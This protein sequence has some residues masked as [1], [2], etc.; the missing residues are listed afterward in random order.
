MAVIDSEVQMELN[1]EPARPE[2]APHVPE[3]LRQRITVQVS[4]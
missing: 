2:D 3:F 4:Q 1:D